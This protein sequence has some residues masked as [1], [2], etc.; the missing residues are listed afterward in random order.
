MIF[1]LNLNLTS[2]N[3][4]CLKSP[5]RNVVFYTLLP[6]NLY[7]VEKKLFQTFHETSLY[8]VCALQ[9]DTTL[10]TWKYKEVFFCTMTPCMHNDNDNDTVYINLD[11]V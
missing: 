3:V 11:K 7:F 1:F 10:S 5:Q 6:L 2:R 9:N 4:C 8:P